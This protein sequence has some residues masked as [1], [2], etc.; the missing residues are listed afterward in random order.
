MIPKQCDVS[1]EGLAP[2]AVGIDS[3]YLSSFLD[4]LGIDW[5]TLR[6]EKEKL[7][8]TPSALYSEIELGDERFALHRGG[9]GRYTFKLSNK[10]FTLA[11]SER[12][13][14]RCHAQFSSHLLW[15][16]GFDAAIARYDK[17]WATTGSRRSRPD[18]INR[19]DA[20]FDFQI[21]PPDFQYEHFVSQAG[22]DATWR[23]FQKSQSY[24]F[25]KS[26][27][28]CRVYDKVAEIEQQS[29]KSWLF[30]KWG[31]SEGVWRCEFQVRNERLRE[32]GI[33]T[34]DQLRAYLPG[35]IKHLAKHHT[36]LRILSG[37]S[38]RSRWPL[39]PM[40]RGIVASV[41]QLTTL[42][43]QPPP[44]LL[45]GTDYQLQRQVRAMMGQ[46]KG[47]AATLSHSRPND[48]VSMEELLRRWPHLAARYHSPELWRADVAE[49]IRKRELGL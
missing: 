41:D 38:N 43:E 9:Q 18:I 17:I 47:I 14:P 30:D 44:P 23:E 15:T 25:G 29:G 32:A 46:L 12:M 37:D 39:H 26:D 4:G 2:C 21:G 6:Y 16:T 7:R 48:P 19:V 36:S 27:V 40:W 24:Q 31:V 13:E 28:V 33:A 5:E 10:A 45:T 42:P 8:A 22:K 35:L 1:D 11:L 20:A 3:L 34:V 49:K